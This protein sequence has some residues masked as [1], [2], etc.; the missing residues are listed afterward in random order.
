MGRSKLDTNIC[1]DGSRCS[2]TLNIFPKLNRPIPEEWYKR[3]VYYKGNSS[4]IGAHG[5]EVKFPQYAE[6]LDLEFEFAA[7]I[8]KGGVNISEGSARKHIYGYTI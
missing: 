2:E 6:N 1:R 7:I 5:Q 4:S 8:G 3:P